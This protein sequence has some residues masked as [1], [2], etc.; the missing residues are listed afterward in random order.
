VDAVTD[1]LLGD[2]DVRCDVFSNI[3]GGAVRLTHLPSGIVATYDYGRGESPI[4]AKERAAALLR[5]RLPADAVPECR[6]ST[7]GDCLQ[8]THGFTL[9][10]EGECIDGELDA[11]AAAARARAAGQPPL[12]RSTR[13]PVRGRLPAG[14]DYPASP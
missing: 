13:Q 14:P 10:P 8:V 5:L 3:A 9:C 4:G 7:T 12:R 6:A 2:P 11:M 1:P